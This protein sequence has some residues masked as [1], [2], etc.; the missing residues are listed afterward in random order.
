MVFITAFANLSAMPLDLE[1][2]TEVIPSF[3]NL[4]LPLV[5]SLALSEPNEYGTPNQ[6][7]TVESHFK[8]LSNHS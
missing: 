5:N 7:N 3:Y 6:A 1:A 8:I 4:I 2:R